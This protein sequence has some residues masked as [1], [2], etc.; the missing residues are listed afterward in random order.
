MNEVT[1][2]L[3]DE[4]VRRFSESFDRLL[5]AVEKKREGVLARVRGN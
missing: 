3:L 2:K 1:G 4:G 5:A